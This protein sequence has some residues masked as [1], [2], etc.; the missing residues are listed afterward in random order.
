MRVPD[1]IHP[2][3]SKKT[4]LVSDIQRDVQPSPFPPFQPLQERELS[5]C[6][7]GRCCDSALLLELEVEKRNSKYD[8]VAVILYAPVRASR[9]GLCMVL[10]FLLIL[11]GGSMHQT[12]AP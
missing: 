7:E 6:P 4:V 11:T 12:A 9:N 5:K 8:E 2:L 10:S 1:V 3:L